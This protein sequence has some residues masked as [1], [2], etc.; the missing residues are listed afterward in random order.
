[1]GIIDIAVDQLVPNPW[2]VNRMSKVMGG[3]L[4]ALCRLHNSHSKLTKRNRRN[5]LSTA[6]NRWL[7]RVQRRYRSARQPQ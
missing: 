4:T 6:T 5:T 3:K 2:N 7:V 1:M